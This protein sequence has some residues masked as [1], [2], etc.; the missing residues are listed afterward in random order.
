MWVLN[1]YQCEFLTNNKINIKADIHISRNKMNIWSEVTDTS[2]L[3]E[4][5]GRSEK[6]GSTARQYVVTKCN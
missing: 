1:I 3:A 4:E 2:V 6:K 5:M